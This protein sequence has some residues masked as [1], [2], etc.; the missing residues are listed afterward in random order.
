MTILSS[1]MTIQASTV[2]CTC[3]VTVIIGSHTR[4]PVHVE[5]CSV[6]TLNS[7]CTLHCVL[8]ND[9]DVLR[10]NFNAYQPILIIFGRDIA[11]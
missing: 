7:L 6:S 5:L 4:N 3:N 1:C 10:Y 11:E 9:S 2:N 8:K